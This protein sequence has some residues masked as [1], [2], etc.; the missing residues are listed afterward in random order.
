MRVH[1]MDVD[2]AVP[3]PARCL[4]DGGY[5]VTA[6]RAHHSL[7]VCFVHQPKSSQKFVETTWSFTTI[8]AQEKSWRMA[9]FY[10]RANIVYFR[11]L[12]ML[13]F[14]KVQCVCGSDVADDGKTEV[15]DARRHSL[16]YIYNQHFNVSGLQR[17]TGRV[18]LPRQFVHFTSETI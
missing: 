9:E 1:A 3:A 2:M 12:L 8:Y 4:S 6:N 16:V 13:A 10:K 5:G 18:T 14:V 7:C 11:I 17:A 15:V